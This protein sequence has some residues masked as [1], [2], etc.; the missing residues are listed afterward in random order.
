MSFVSVRQ[1]DISCAIE[2]K[3]MLTASNAY[4]RHI[5]EGGI[6]FLIVVPE[7]IRVTEKVLE[8][9]DWLV[10]CSSARPEDAVWDIAG[11]GLGYD[12][13]TALLELSAFL[14]LQASYARVLFDAINLTPICRIDYTDDA[15]CMYTCVKGRMSFDAKGMTM[16]DDYDDRYRILMPSEQLQAL[17]AAVV[18]SAM[19]RGRFLSSLGWDTSVVQTFLTMLD[20]P[21]DVPQH[22]TT[23]TLRELRAEGSVLVARVSR[24]QLGGKRA[25]EGRV[26][27]YKPNKPNKPKCDA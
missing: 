1:G 4:I 19:A 5:D 18:D 2:K 8:C 23:T 17:R 24:R 11:S 10:R 22:E 14:E 13:T 7:K 20:V 16:Y 25:P 9:L 26:D 12:E 6:P 21:L 15:E 3:D 27:L